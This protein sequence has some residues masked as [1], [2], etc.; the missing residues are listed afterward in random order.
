MNILFVMPRELS[1][2]GI[3]TISTELAKKMIEYGHNVDFV[4]HGY[5]KGC[6]ENY[7]LEKGSKIYHIP[8]K[9]KNYFKMRQQFKRVLLAKKYDVVHAHMNATSGIYLKIAKKNGIKVLVAHS[10]ASSIDAITNNKIKIIINNIEKIKTRKYA[11]LKFACSDKA[12]RWLYG[13]E[14]YTV[15]LNAVDSN[16]YSFSEEVRR[17]ERNKLN[18]QDNSFVI[19]QVGS[20]S[21][22]KNHDYT[23]RVYNNYIRNNR[24]I[25]I[26]FAGDGPEKSRIQEMVQEMGLQD[27][28]L[29]LGQRDDIDKLLQVAD[30]FVMPSVSEG[31]PLSLVEALASGIKCIVS[32]NVPDDLRN[33]FVNDIFYI[34]INNLNEKRWCDE[35]IKK[36]I[37]TIYDNN[38]KFPLDIS[39][40]TKQ[41]IE[42]YN[43]GLK[44]M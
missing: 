25:Y 34:P 15:I 38:K 8:I 6:K 26:L 36:H 19:I 13:D 37:R 10:H 39:I 28:V 33:L 44:K 27:N 12:G 14:R 16:K 32:T 21:K 29:F 18:L 31:N 23:L 5:E 1:Y 30:V 43:E 11:N 40:M 4:C 22:I 41:V 7:F 20:F 9:S 35:T 42:M 17:N 3:E 2:G 24:S